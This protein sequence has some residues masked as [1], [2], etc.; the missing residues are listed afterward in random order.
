MN[1]KALAKHH[2]KFTPEERVRLILA[3]VARKDIEE[4]NGLKARCPQMNLVGPHPEYS[5]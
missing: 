2:E 4:A 1:A 3:A 5:K